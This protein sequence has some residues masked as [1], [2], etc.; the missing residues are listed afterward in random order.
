[1]AVPEVILNGVDVIYRVSFTTPFTG[2]VGV[3]ITAYQIELL[4]VS[5]DWQVPS[6]CISD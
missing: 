1:M 5:G 4:T 6:T 2:G 3:Q